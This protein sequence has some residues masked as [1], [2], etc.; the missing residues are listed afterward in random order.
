MLI[1]Q[2][3]DEIKLELIDELDKQL[4]SFLTH[5]VTHDE[6]GQCVDHY[7]TTEEDAEANHIQ[8]RVYP[9]GDLVFPPDV[10]IGNVGTSG[11]GGIGGGGLGGGAG[12][13]GGG[14]GGGGGFGGGGGGF[15]SISDPVG[16]IDLQLKKKPNIVR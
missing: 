9:V 15:F 5:A 8:T 13:V 12:G 10:M 6:A 2:L 14:L 4:E 11:G 1:R 3:S 16:E 7:F